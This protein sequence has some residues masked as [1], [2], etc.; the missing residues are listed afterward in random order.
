MKTQKEIVSSLLSL[1]LN[2]LNRME[3]CSA[4]EMDINIMGDMEL[5]HIALDIIGFPE[6]NTL[7]FDFNSLNSLPADGKRT[8]YEN[9][10]CRD[11]LMDP[12]YNGEESCINLHEYI[13]W[14]YNEFNKLSIGDKTTQE[15]SN[16]KRS[17]LN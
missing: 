7:E 16:M 10:F 11:W 4:L 3:I 17:Q 6:D 15:V 8:D 12:F 13:E 2:C 1:Q 9:M 5:W 14:L